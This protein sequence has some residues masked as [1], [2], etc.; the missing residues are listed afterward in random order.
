[1]SLLSLTYPLLLQSCILRNRYRIVTIVI[2]PTSTSYGA[3]TGSHCCV[4]VS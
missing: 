4:C 2:R 3:V 1:M